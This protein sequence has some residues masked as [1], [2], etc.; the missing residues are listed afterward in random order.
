MSANKVADRKM[1]K[2]KDESSYVERELDASAKAIDQYRPGHSAH[3]DLGRNLQ[4]YHWSNTFIAHACQR[5]A[6]H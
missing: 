3:A 5:T 2:K 1:K 6:L 4:Y